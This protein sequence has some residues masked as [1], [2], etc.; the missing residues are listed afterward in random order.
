MP[1]AVRNTFVYDPD[2]RRTRKQDTTGTTQFV[3]DSANVLAE[4]DGSNVVQAIYTQGPAAFGS[5]LS[6]YRASSGT[7]F[8]H[9]DGL[10]STDRLT[11]AGSVVTDN[12]V[13]DAYGSP[14]GGTNS[15]VNPFQY[16]GRL[17]YYNDSDLA[18]YYVRARFTTSRPWAGS[19]RPTRWPT[20]C[21][22][23][24]RA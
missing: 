12:Y 13:Y 19:C 4:T 20:P 3:W 24:C 16:V 11:N 8:F 14:R 15:S 5:V 7:Q 22:A 9:F 1:S 17:G 6:Q 21:W 10:G 23:A 18:Q 2:G